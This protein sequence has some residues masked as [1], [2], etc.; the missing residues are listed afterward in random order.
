[1]EELNSCKNLHELRS[2]E[3]IKINHDENYTPEVVYS[4]CNKLLQRE[5]I[6]VDVC[7]INVKKKKRIDEKDKPEIIYIPC[8]CSVLIWLLN[9]Y[10]TFVCGEGM[11]V[12]WKPLLRV[13]DVKSVKKKKG[14]DT[15]E[16]NYCVVCKFR[17]ATSL[18]W[19]YNRFDI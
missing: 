11:E 18:G 15:R 2:R 19:L 10:E 6:Y 4:I 1:M 7:E 3:K 5:G 13:L 12:E 8:V 17:I 9:I 14:K 16:A